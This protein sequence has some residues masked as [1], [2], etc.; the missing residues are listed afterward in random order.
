MLV[1]LEVPPLESS[2]IVRDFPEQ[3]TAEV[4]NALGIEFFW[5]ILQTPP[6]LFWENVHFR[7]AA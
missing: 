7:P 2:R 6:D 3:E 5:M 1:P 4:P